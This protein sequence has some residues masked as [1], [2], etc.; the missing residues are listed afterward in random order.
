MSQTFEYPNLLTGSRSGAGWSYD[1]GGMRYEAL[2][3]GFENKQH[4]LLNSTK[5][6]NFIRSPYV[7]LKHGIAYA[8]SV[9]TANG[10]NCAGSD[11]F[12]LY[13]QVTDG[14]IAGGI[15]HCEK[16]PVGGRSLLCSRSQIPLRKATTASDS[17]TTDQQMGRMH[18]FG[19]AA[20]CYALL[21]NRMHGLQQ[22]GRCGRK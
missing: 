7:L 4:A 9:Y 3:R 2:E 13:N 10:S 18:S 5:N 8:F 11:I 19:S 6:E 22:R 21:Q 12:V 16:G 17:T 20:R 1:N 14:W 15:K